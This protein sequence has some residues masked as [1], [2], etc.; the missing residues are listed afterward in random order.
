MCRCLTV[1][2]DKASQYCKTV[3]VDFQHPN[4]IF[5]LESIYD[6]KELFAKGSKKSEEFQNFSGF[7]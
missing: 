5:A 1:K 6:R 2:Y 4:K 7:F 3:A